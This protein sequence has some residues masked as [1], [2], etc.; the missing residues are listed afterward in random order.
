MKLMLTLLY[1]NLKNHPHWLIIPNKKACHCKPIDTFPPF[2]SI[3]QTIIEIIAVDINNH[4][5]LFHS[6]K[7]K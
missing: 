2:A 3:A 5:F 4:F 7:F 6:F 1:T